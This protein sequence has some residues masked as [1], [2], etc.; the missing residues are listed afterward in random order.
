MNETWRLWRHRGGLFHLGVARR[1]PVARF[2]SF[3]GLL[4]AP[5]AFGRAFRD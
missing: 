5:I 4:F 1:F 2:T 3:F